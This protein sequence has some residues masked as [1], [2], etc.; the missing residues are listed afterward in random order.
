MPAAYPSTLPQPV[1]GGVEASVNMGVIRSDMTAR[2]AQRRVHTAMPHRFTLTFVITSLKWGPWYNWMKANG[3]RWFYISL[4]S[5]YAG[6]AGTNTSAVL[7]RLT[8]GIEA[9]S[10]TGSDVTVTVSAES[11]PSMIGAYLDG[12]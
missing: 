1:V 4:P 12:L 2:Q 5:L 11:A 8:S 7:V 3:Y 9:R 6:L 10:V